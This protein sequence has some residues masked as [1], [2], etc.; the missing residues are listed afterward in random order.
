MKTLHKAIACAAIGAITITSSIISS[1]DHARLHDTEADRA[2]D[3]AE[4]LRG[5][6]PWAIIEQIPGY[7]DGPT[8]WEFAINYYARL[9]DETDAQPVIML[10]YIYD[11][12]KQ[13]MSA[14]AM[15]LFSQYG[16]LYVA[17]QNRP[18]ATKVSLD[19]LVTRN[20][21]S[22]ANAAFHQHLDDSK[23]ANV[24][25]M[26]VFS[27]SFEHG[28]QDIF[29]DFKAKASDQMTFL[30]HAYFFPLDYTQD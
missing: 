26:A 16:S 24:E 4:R 9:I 20:D 8:C 23:T 7:G 13:Q 12:S 1:I 18:Y 10:L 14:H 30:G 25:A 28:K 2:A 17:D 29:N 19:K 11:Y 15:V 6:R 21:L 27:V 22:I 5:F 3:T